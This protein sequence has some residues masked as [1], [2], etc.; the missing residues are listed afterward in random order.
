MQKIRMLTT[1]LGSD[2]DAMGVNQGP[3]L[4]HADEEYS[5]CDNLTKCF[6]DMGAVELVD[7]QDADLKDSKGKNRQKKGAGREA[8]PQ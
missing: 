3:K 6:I 2:E 8:G 5:V 4:Y 1:C 7:E